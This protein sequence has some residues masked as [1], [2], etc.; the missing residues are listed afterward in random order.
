[1]A[2]EHSVGISLRI[3]PC[4]GGWQPA[5][6]DFLDDESLRF[7]PHFLKPVG[8]IRFCPV[9]AARARGIVAERAKLRSAAEA[10]LQLRA[11]I[12][13]RGRVLGT[14]T[15]RAGNACFPRGR[16]TFWMGKRA[17]KENPMVLQRRRGSFYSKN[18]GSGGTGNP[19]W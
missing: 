2:A 6:G 18:K 11:W 10:R 1:M 14:G 8:G 15:F 5:W 17:E 4:D 16:D 9:S 12:E 7:F 19:S 3:L 13:K